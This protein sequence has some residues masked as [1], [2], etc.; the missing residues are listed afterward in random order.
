MSMSA[1]EQVYRACADEHRE[2][3]DLVDRIQALR[4]I[5]GLVPLLE[6]LHALLIKHFSQEHFPGGLYER[7]GAFGSE[8]HEELKVLV[9]EHCTIL[10]AVRGLLDHSRIAGAPDEPALLK[11]L[12]KVLTQLRDHEHR[13]Y[14]LADKLMASAKRKAN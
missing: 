9:R 5:K 2:L 10:S 12:T 8:H 6:K 3:M 1:F 4:S 14:V 13:E 11:E 7:I